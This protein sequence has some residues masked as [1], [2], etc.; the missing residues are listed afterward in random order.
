M[1]RFWYEWETSGG[2]SYYLV[3]PARG[4]KA[5]IFDNDRIAAELTRLTKDPWDGQHLPIRGITFIDANTLRF[6]V[7]SSQDA[8]EEESETDETDQEQQQE[9]DDVG[10]RRG[11]GRRSICSTSSTTSPVGPFAC[12]RIGKSPTTIRTGRTCHQTVRR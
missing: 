3:D 5:A 8:E 10:R 2:K 12:S 6:E 7:E 11:N 9:E 1:D 4:T